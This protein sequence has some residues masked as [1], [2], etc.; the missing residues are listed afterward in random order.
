ML[1]F[2]VCCFLCRPSLL[3][4]LLVGHIQELSETSKQLAE[5]TGAKDIVPNWDDEEEGGREEHRRKTRRSKHVNLLPKNFILFILHIFNSSNFK[6]PIHFWWWYWYWTN[7]YNT[8]KLH[9]LLSDKAITLFPKLSNSY[10]VHL[11]HNS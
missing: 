10:F 1:C 2:H 8:P 5:L 4:L 6:T 11:H 3:C 7:K 9:D